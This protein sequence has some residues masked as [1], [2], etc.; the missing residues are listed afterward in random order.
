MTSTVIA[1]LL[2]FLPHTET[3]L[4]QIDNLLF[5]E[6]EVNGRAASFIVDSGSPVTILDSRQAK[7]FGF[8]AVGPEKKVDGL[9][10]THTWRAVSNANFYINSQKLFPILTTAD[11]L[12]MHQHFSKSLPAPFLGI[13][14]ND[15]L[16]NYKAAIDTE[17]NEIT[18]FFN[19]KPTTNPVLASEEHSLFESMKK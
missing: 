16:T 11:L 18:F 2:L 9:C 12:S 4:H 1:L 7:R 15:I 5:V 3:P 13:I 14:G 8:K 6:M 19:K 10:K 17:A